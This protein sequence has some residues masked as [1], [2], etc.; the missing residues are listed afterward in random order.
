MASLIRDVV[1]NYNE[2]VKNIKD[3]VID[4]WPLMGSPG[5]VLCIVGVYLIYVLK[6]GPKMMEKKPAFQLNTVMILYNAF[7]VLFSIWLASLTQQVD[8][9]DLFTFH[10]CNLHLPDAEIKH[11]QAVISRLAWWYFFAKMIELLDTIFFILRK[12]QN[13]VTFLHVYHHS[14]MAIW[15]WCYLKFLPGEQGIVVGFLNSVV[16]IIMYSYYFVAA[17]GS[18]Y[19]KYLWW[20]KYMTKIQLLQFVLML[21]YLLLTL[22]MDCRLPKALSYFFVT[23]VTIFI[24]L[25]SDFYRKAYK[26]K[27]A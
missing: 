5:P 11:K 8:I 24:Y 27:T 4:T 16:H 19:R 2:A 10:G 22:V 20:K 3:P 21:F 9:K 13:Q 17:L 25:F 23:N 14:S 12:K 6:V 18:K 7:Q 26:T 15:S 1:S